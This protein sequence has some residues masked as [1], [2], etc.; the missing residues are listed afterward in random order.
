MNSSILPKLSKKKLKIKE[1]KKIVSASLTSFLVKAI[2]HRFLPKLKTFS[3]NYNDSQSRTI[4][5]KN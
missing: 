2:F 1:K 5:L 4:F 3:V